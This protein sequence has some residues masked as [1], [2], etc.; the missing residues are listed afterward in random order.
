MNR[1]EGVTVVLAV[2]AAPFGAY[3]STP[4]GEQGRDK[5]ICKWQGGHTG[6]R[7]RK[8][9]CRTKEQSER[10]SEQH[11]R[12]AKEMIDRPATNIAREF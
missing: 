5:V 11:K 8:K 2:I 1:W 6:T 10:I 9:V 4:P 3:A 12:D 7:F